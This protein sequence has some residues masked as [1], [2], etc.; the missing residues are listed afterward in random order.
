MLS[1]LV[2][3]INR[4]KNAVAYYGTNVQFLA[5]IGHFLVPYSII[6]T[7]YRLGL[8]EPGKWYVLGITIVWAAWKEYYF[9]ARYEVPHQ[10]FWDNTEDFIGYF[11]G[12]A[13]ACFTF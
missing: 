1:T 7:L 3:I 5:N 6:A 10:T 8:E 11:S 13:L 12:A 2:G 9:D 4:L